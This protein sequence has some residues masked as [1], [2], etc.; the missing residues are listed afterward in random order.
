L[1]LSFVI[2]FDRVREAKG[3]EFDACALIGFFSY[4]ER[5]QSG[6][7]W[8]NMIL[9]LSSETG[10]TTTEGQFEPCDYLLS[11]PEVEDE[12]MLLYTA[13]TRARNRL[14]LIEFEDDGIRRK[15]GEKGIADYVYRH[16]EQLDGGLVK[17]VTQ[18]DEGKKEITPQQHK[19]RGVRMITKAIAKARS[20]STS[21]TEIRI[22]FE[23]AMKMFS[24]AFGNDRDLYDLTAQQMEATI[25][26]IKLR[27]RIETTFFEKN[28]GSFNLDKKFQEML[29]FEQE[30]VKYMEHTAWNTFMTDDFHE[31]VSLVEEMISGTPY[32]G[33]LGKYLTKLSMS[34]ESWYQEICELSNVNQ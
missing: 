16:L 27:Q 6:P 3:L 33:W 22:M 11:H 8:K 30:L 23:Q 17:R 31:I 19:A 12:A 9:W 5:R 29:K 14:Y 24:P 28:S 15:K 13:L 18:I 4:F 20:S 25:L 2:L 10:L 1:L 34:H 32:E 7:Q 21:T 26:K